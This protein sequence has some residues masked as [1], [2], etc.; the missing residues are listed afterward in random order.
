MKKALLILTCGCI[1]GINT[2]ILSPSIKSICYIT[3]NQIECL[4]DKEEDGGGKPYIKCNSGSLNN[5]IHGVYSVV[6]CGDCLAH[7]VLITGDGDCRIN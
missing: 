1:A 2:I 4:A 3:F 6:W 5:G 7:R